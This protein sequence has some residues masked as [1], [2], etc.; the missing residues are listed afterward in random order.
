MWASSVAWWLRRL[1]PTWLIMQFE[2]WT[3]QYEKHQV[4]EC[5]RPISWKG[6]ETE[7]KG[8]GMGGVFSLSLSVLLVE[9]VHPLT[10]KKKKWQ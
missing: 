10:G 1:K 2:P 3:R 9:H 7:E 6:E 8:C 4:H 5:A